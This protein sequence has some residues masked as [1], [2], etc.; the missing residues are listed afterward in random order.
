MPTESRGSIGQVKPSGWQS[1]KY[2]NIDGKYLYNRCH[3]IGYQLTAENANRLNLITGTRYLNVTGMLPFEN[4]TADYIKETGN[5]VL[6][7][8]TPIFEGDNLIADGVQ[9]EARSVEDDGE[10]VLFHVFCYNVQPG[11]IIDYATGESRLESDQDSQDKQDNL[12]KQDNSK[13]QD[14]QENQ[15]NTGKQ[16][17]Q[18]NADLDDLVVYILNTNT[19]KFH[20]PT[21]S[22]AIRMNENDRQEYTGDRQDLIDE[23]Y[24]PCKRC[25]P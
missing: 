15:N 1:T 25:N 14:N 7:R 23:G 21:C 3:L 4:L 22:S 13:N 5:H 10:G 16:D 19:R 8:V 11:I 24:E 18:N 20:L 12:D 9:M 6:Y 17:E 2:D